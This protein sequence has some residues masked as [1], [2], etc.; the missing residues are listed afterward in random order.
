MEYQV[1]QKSIEASRA[2]RA[3]VQQRNKAYEAVYKDKAINPF[4][5]KSYKS[6]FVTT[7]GLNGSFLHAQECFIEAAWPT[8]DNFSVP[9]DAPLRHSPLLDLGVLKL[10]RSE[11]A[12][13][14]SP[15]GDFLKDRTR[16]EKKLLCPGRQKFVQNV[17]TTSLHSFSEFFTGIQAARVLM[18]GE[19]LGEFVNRLYPN[20]SSDSPLFR[21]RSHLLS[22]EPYPDDGSQW[23]DK[24]APRR[25]SEVLGNREHLP[26]IQ[27]WLDEWKVDLSSSNLS[28]MTSKP[29]PVKKP[30]WR[31]SKKPSYGSD[32][33]D[34]ISDDSGDKS[35]YDDEVVMSRKHLLLAGPTASCKTS[36]V[37][38]LAREMG[39][40]VF[41]VGPNMRRT[42]KDLLGALGEMAV[43]HLVGA[44]WAGLG[45]SEVPATLKETEIS[46]KVMSEV[47]MQGSVGNDSPEKRK[48]PKKSKKMRIDDSDED[49]E[50]T[51]R[52][53]PKPI[54]KRKTRLSDDSDHSQTKQT[55]TAI[56]TTLNSTT[57]EDAEKKPSKKLRKQSFNIDMVWNLPEVKFENDGSVK[58][59]G[60]DSPRIV[61]S[62][63]IKK[64]TLKLTPPRPSAHDRAPEQVNA[65]MPIFSTSAKPK[66]SLIFLEEVDVLYEQDKG[67]WASVLA[68]MQ[69]TRR[70]IVMT[71]AGTSH[72]SHLLM[73]IIASVIVTH[74]TVR[75]CLQHLQQ[76]PSAR[77]RHGR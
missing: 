66:Q 11:Q 69:K 72:C 9:C 54:K 12:F 50:G 29:K 36:T 4:F 63:T 70:P 10:R 51:P 61:A 39:Y 25:A 2:L 35:S 74:S 43:S 46:L 22:N 33:D 68:L 32:L 16:S 73:W 38:A 1:Q 13:S 17:P 8:A 48:K 55:S 47:S 59:N 45:E 56:N 7:T 44:S 62:P 14:I 76:N 30:K 23:V 26:T 20:V 49:F 31:K 71:S 21:V 64:L 67:F 65:S 53:E 5:Q 37:Y 28:A 15:L 58:R 75:L 77:V 19:L 57:P 34:F 24:Y 3:E 52:R 60:M 40:E 6:D 18:S 42:G 41:E 27:K